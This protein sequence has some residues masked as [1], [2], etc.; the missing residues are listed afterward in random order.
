LD[1]DVPLNPDP[2]DPDVPLN[3]D[4]L[5]PDVPLYTAPD[6]PLDPAI[7]TVP[8]LPNNLKTSNVSGAGLSSSI[9]MLY[10]ILCNHHQ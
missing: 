10:L 9:V 3:P 8:T 6:D 7:K 2:L 4:P 5:D 1:P